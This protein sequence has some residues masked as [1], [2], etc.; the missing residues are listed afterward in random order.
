MGIVLVLL[1]LLSAAVVIDFVIEN[2]LA[3]A[4]DRSFELFGGSFTLNQT[5]VVLAAAVLGGIA[6]LFLVLGLG[7]SR[8]S[9]GRRRAQ[10]HRISELERQ[11]AELR[12]TP[13]VVTPVVAERT[14]DARTDDDGD[15]A[16]RREALAAERETDTRT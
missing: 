10:R 14:V 8:G 1:G 9:W 4:P 15:D 7:I 3:G 13:A 11:N 2:D 12:S 16:R 5:E 6:I